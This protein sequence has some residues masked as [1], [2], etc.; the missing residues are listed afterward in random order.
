MRHTIDLTPELEQLLDECLEPGAY[1]AHVEQILTVD[2]RLWRA[3]EG[4]T[5]EL[6]RTIGGVHAMVTGAR[7]MHVLAG[8]QIAYYGEEQPTAWESS[9]VRSKALSAGTAC[10]SVAP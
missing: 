7:E 5:L 3:S 10:G 1:V 8:A 2:G 9:A 4:Y 6:Y